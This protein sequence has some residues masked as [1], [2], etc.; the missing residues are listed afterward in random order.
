M[1][2]VRHQEWV[3]RIIVF[4]IRSKMIDV[5]TLFKNSVELNSVEKVVGYVNIVTIKY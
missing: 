4:T 1:A 5:G 2:K 3:L